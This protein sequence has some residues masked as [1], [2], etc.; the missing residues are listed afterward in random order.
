LH[1]GIDR[2]LRHRQWNLRVVY[3][4][5]CRIQ[6]HWW[7]DRSMRYR[8]RRARLKGWRKWCRCKASICQCCVQVGGYH[9]KTQI[10]P[11]P[12]ANVKRTIA[13]RSMDPPPLPA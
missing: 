9:D 3:L 8:D 4:R 7:S 10:R 12:P 13:L 5:K 11:T 6:K 1:R 2:M